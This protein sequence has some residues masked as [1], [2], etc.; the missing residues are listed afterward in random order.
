MEMATADLRGVLPA[1][2]AERV[3]ALCD[4]HGVRRA[5]EARLNL[6]SL[7]VRGGLCIRACGMNTLALAPPPPPR[8]LRWY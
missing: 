6:V 4:A 1:T 5:F 8:R 7:E 3:L 2:K